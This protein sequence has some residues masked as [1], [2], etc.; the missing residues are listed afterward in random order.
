MYP[1]REDSLSL[2]SWLAP[3]E[4]TRQRF[5]RARRQPGSKQHPLERCSEIPL[6][7]C[8]RSEPELLQPLTAGVLL[9]QRD[10]GVGAEGTWPS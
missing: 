9:W 8:S 4:G 3:R 1:P 7:G 6:E 10:A 2:G 5:I